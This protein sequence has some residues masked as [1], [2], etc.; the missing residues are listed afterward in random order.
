MARRV[1]AYVNRFFAWCMKRD[2]LK[3]DPT[4]GMSKV[5]VCKSR[6][7][8]LNDEA[9]AGSAA[10]GTFGSIVRLLALTGARREEIAQLR[11]SEE[12]TRPSLQCDDAAVATNGYSAISGAEQHRRD[13]FFL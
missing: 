8:V 3:I 10:E 2:I 7:R 9:K 12:R 4:A 6:E 11:W 13:W 1:E 5:G